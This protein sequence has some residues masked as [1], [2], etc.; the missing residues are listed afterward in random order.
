MVWCTEHAAVLVGRASAEKAHL[1][2]RTAKRHSSLSILR[3]PPPVLRLNAPTASPISVRPAYPLRRFWHRRH[4]RHH[5]FCVVAPL[6]RA[7]VWHK[8]PNFRQQFNPGLLK[9]E[10]RR[11][12]PPSG[13]DYHTIGSGNSKPVTVERIIPYILKRFIRTD[14]ASIRTRWH[15]AHTTGRSAQS[16][17]VEPS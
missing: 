12:R 5:R 11:V 7:S 16:A 10:P 14:R 1:A 8:R 2:P 3:R 9:A 17:A 15:V 4:R 13:R 6:A